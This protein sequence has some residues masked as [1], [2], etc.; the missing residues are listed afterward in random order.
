MVVGQTSGQC[1]NPKKRTT[2]L[3]RK[4]AS[5]RRCPLWSVRSSALPKS[6]PV[7]SVNSNFGASERPQA[8]SKNA[9]VSASSALQKHARVVVDQ[10]GGKER[11]KIRDRKAERAPRERVAVVDVN[12]DRIPQEQSPERAGREQVDHAAHAHHERQQR[13]GEQ[14]HRIQQDVQSRELVAVRDGQHGYPGFRILVLAIER[15][16]PEVRRGPG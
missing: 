9:R 12:A 4:S 6:A 16:R 13:T 2:T 1:V 8:A 5:V 10:E 11:G 14:N 7:M 15:E 3:P